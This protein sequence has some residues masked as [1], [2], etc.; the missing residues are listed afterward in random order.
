MQTLLILGGTTEARALAQ[1]CSTA[2]PQ[3][4]VLTS[5]AGSTRNPLPLAGETRRGGF[6]GGDGLARFLATHK[7]D[8]LIDAT[9]PFASAI[10]AYAAETC[11]AQSITH[12]ILLRP[13]WQAIEGDDWLGV[14]DHAAAAKSLQS[15]PRKVFLA[16]GHKDI[17]RFTALTEHNFLIRLIETPTRPLAFKRYSLILARGPFSI[18]TE[19]QLLHQHQIAVLVSKNS[20][21]AAG[22]SKIAAARE[23]GLPVVM[24]TRPPAP[25][26]M[27]VSCVED[28][29]SWLQA[30]LSLFNGS[31]DTAV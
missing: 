25:P 21:G 14:A 10:S 1:Q 29:L 26:G 19:K 18:A 12:L 9:H 17:E 16:T 11:K 23:L 5:L 13:P 28:A 15:L 7:V 24:I 27:T 2:Y 4:R 31:N 3:L 8:L 30:R 20:G 22:Y 6:G